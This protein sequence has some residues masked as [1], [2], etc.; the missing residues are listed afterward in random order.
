M[1]SAPAALH[2]RPLGPE[3]NRCWGEINGKQKEIQA[4]IKMSDGVWSRANKKDVSS[5]KPE[6]SEVS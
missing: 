4:N 3:E 6:T 2:K 1:A 5:P